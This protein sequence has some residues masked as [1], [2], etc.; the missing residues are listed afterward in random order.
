MVLAPVVSSRKGGSADDLTGTFDLSAFK[1]EKTQ[2][3]WTLTVEDAARLIGRP[4]ARPLFVSITCSSA[5][6]VCTTRMPRPPPPPAA[7]MITG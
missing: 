6:S 2:G 5:A 1:G 7:L 4:T 3:T